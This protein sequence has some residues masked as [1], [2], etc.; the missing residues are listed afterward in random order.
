MWAKSKHGHIKQHKE[1]AWYSYT[2]IVEWDGGL[3]PTLPPRLIFKASIAFWISM[4]MA[5][6]TLPDDSFLCDFCK[7]SFNE[8][9]L[10]PA[11]FPHIGQTFIMGLRCCHSMETLP[12]NFRSRS[13]SILA[14]PSFGWARRWTRFRV[15]QAFNKVK[16]LHGEKHLHWL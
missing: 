3:G 9:L 1:W 6:S 8:Q 14:N 15:F 11:F 7:C 13:T 16:F 5:L 10:N 2:S 4:L 12:C